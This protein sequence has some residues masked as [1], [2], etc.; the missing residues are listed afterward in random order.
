MNAANITTEAAFLVFSEVGKSRADEG[1]RHSHFA[2][3][4][5]DHKACGRAVV[6]SIPRIQESIILKR[7]VSAENPELSDQELTL[8]V[9]GAGTASA[10]CSTQFG[11]WL[12]GGD[13]GASDVGAKP[14]A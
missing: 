10:G 12:T 3:R 7:R 11:R 4:E 5:G 6:F 8:V 2:W 9:G 13:G 1:K 14:G